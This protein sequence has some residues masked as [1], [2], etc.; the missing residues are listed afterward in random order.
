MTRYTADAVVTVDEVHRPGVL[1]VVDGIVAWAGPAPAAPEPAGPVVPLGGLVMPGLVNAHAHTPMTLL[2]GT[3]DGLPLARWLEEAIWPVEARLT[4]DDVRWGML[5][6]C[7]EMLRCGVTTTAE[8]YLHA[9]AVAEGALESGIRCAL[10]PVVYPMPDGS[11]W[12]RSLDEAGEVFDDF[13]GRAGRLTVG[14]GPHSYYALPEDGL[15][16]TA[17]LAGELGALVQIHVAETAAEDRDV[18]QRLARLGL[19]DCRVVAAHSVWLDDADLDLYRRHD[20]AVA[21]CPQ[22]NGKLG[23]GVARLAEMLA[24]GLRVGLGTDGPASNDNLDLWE[25]LRL[26]PLLAR[27]VAGDPL[28]VPTAAA[29]RLATSGGAEALGLPTGRLAPGLAA[30]FIR[31]DTDDP[32]FVP[33]GDEAELQAHLVW[34]APSRLVT[35]VWVGGRQVVADGRCT[36]V[37]VG[38]ASRQVRARAHRLREGPP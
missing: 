29:L 24:R 38:E 13:D 11:S 15:V 36:T 18:P 10:A 27:A 20:V 25:E 4:D 8:M 33:C 16:A 6:G 34:A 23:S 2:R 12:H 22:S 19:F 37:D 9:R 28:A 32:S 17:R 7:A 26:A 3:G 1:D 5:L 30:D 31:V 21:H 14:F 35:D